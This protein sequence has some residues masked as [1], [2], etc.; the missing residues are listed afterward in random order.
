M[1]Y[2]GVHPPSLEEI[3]AAKASLRKAMSIDVLDGPE[4]VQTD[5]QNVGFC[6]SVQSFQSPSYQNLNYRQRPLPA[7]PSAPPD[8]EDLYEQLSQHPEDAS[9]SSGVESLPH[10]V[11]LGKN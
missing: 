4:G 10:D 2:G 8:Q 5:Y 7:A 6:L 1:A 11:S 9:T 3:S